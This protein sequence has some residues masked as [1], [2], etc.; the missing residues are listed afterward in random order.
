MANETGK[1][2]MDQNKQSTGT[3]TTQ[4]GS[5]SSG[6]SYNQQDKTKN[7]PTQDSMTDPNKKD[8][9][10]DPTKDYKSN[11]QDTAE[12]DQGDKRRAS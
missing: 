5:Q 7:N 3:S 4:Q 11:D 6:T 8:V 12:I 2:D 9:R 10:K 1:R